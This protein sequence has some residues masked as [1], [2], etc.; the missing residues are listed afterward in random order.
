MPIVNP[1]VV[2]VLVMP[3]FGG[4][5]GRTMMAAL[6]FRVVEEGSLGVGALVWHH[7]WSGVLLAVTHVS[8]VMLLLR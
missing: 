6:V 2:M 1:T 5:T 4:I 7:T 8:R 3:L